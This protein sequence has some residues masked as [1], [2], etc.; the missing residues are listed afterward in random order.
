M[1]RKRILYPPV[2][3][4]FDPRKLRRARER[5]KLQ[6]K[7]VERATDIPAQTIYGI[8]AGLAP[9]SAYHLHLLVKLYGLDAL[10]VA[11]ILKINLATPLEL[12]MF[13]AACAREG[14]TPAQVIADFVRVYPEVVKGSHA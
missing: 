14:K 10:E 1:N 11:E 8:E 12:K 7:E 5:L 9:P 2:V 3:S 4:Y 6:K 13:R